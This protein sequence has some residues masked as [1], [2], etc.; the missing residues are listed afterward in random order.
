MSVKLGLSICF[1]GD[2]FP[3]S[4]LYRSKY[5]HRA[6]YGLNGVIYLTLCRVSILPFS[7]RRCL[8]GPVL[9]ILIVKLYSLREQ[10]SYS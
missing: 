5:S 8:H 3:C 6:K 10:N 1:G 7:V 9:M 4:A 2:P